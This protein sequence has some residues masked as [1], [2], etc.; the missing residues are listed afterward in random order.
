[1]TWQ[2]TPE[3]LPY[4]GVLFL[5]VLLAG[6]LT[7]Y[8]VVVWTDAMHQPTVRAFVGLNVGCAL[9][10][11]A[12]AMQLLSVT[13]S[14]KRGWLTV[15][16]LGAVLVSVS[17]FTF[18]VAYSGNERLLSR[19]TALVLAIEPIVAF[20]LF[21]TQYRNLYTQRVDTAVVSDLVMIDR[22][23][24][25]MG[26]VHVLYL[27]G[28][29]VL[30]AGFLLRT[31]YRANHVYR[32]QASAVLLSIFVP[33][34]ANV[35][36]FLELGP[37]GNLD[38][39]PVAFVVS[40]LVYAVAISQH[41]LLDVVPVARTAVVENMRDG[42]LV[43]DETNRV[44]DVNAAVRSQIADDDNESIIG[45][46]IAAVFPEVMRIV[47]DGPST[48]HAQIA[49]DSSD[50]RRLF[51]VQVQRLSNDE[52]F[53]LLLLRD[54]TDQHAVE[55]RYQ[56]L[57][58]NASDLITVIDDNGV[59]R[60]QSPSSTNVLG[61]DPSALEDRNY[62]EFVHPDDRERI[63]GAFSQGIEEP[64]SSER[65]EYRIRDADGEWRDV[66][67][68][69]RNLLDDP[70]VDG[71]VL[72]TR[73][74]TE[75]KKREREIRRKNDQLEEFAGVVSHDLRNPLTIA[76]GYLE[77]A[78]DAVDCEY[79]DDIEFAHDRIET[80]IG[81]VL[82]LAREGQ[83]IGETERVDVEQAV[84]QAWTHVDTGEASLTVVSDRPIVADE[85]RFLQ[86]LENLFRN[87]IE[88]GGSDVNVRVETVADGF[89]VEDDGPGIPADDRR[90]VLKYGYTKTE[91]GTGF[92]LAIV[93]RIAEGHGWSIRVTEGTD[94][95]ARFEFVTDSQPITESLEEDA[96]SNG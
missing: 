90:D 82:V 25:P 81:D 67:T 44:R 95:G 89:F 14:T 21:T 73:D 35:V 51:E 10:A 77:A 46:D 59:I 24:G 56:A 69:G 52:R 37:M 87:A 23:F 13:V 47:R 88:H 74:V 5:S 54:V 60:Y 78:R 55:Q 85:D 9:W 43:I 58:E 4:V 1:M 71:V 31:I 27:Y 3:I 19:R 70:F 39:T 22:T 72:N 84:E 20:V 11:G 18:A 57:I 64:S 92:G 66:E 34:L 96:L 68:V 17:C 63:A 32:M 36:W 6:G 65:E 61:Y 79:H 8:T 94:G 15:A 83:A 2:Y 33:L 86:L 29:L 28:L 93:S 40:G 75:R 38:F 45:R 41:Q 30:S 49:V 48:D 26:I 80:I 12:Y 7:V 91:A 50:R 76:Q 53:R 16:F 42:F 62:T